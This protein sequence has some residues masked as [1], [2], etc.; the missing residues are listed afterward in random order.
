MERNG[1][2]NMAII[3]VRDMKPPEDEM[4]DVTLALQYPL[5]GDIT[6]YIQ[7]AIDAVTSP[8]D[9]VVFEPELHLFS[10][11]FRLKECTLNGNGATLR[12][13]PGVHFDCWQGNGNTVF[14]L[15]EG[16]AP[17]RVRMM[18]FIFDGDG[19]VDAVLAFNSAVLAF[20]SAEAEADEE[21]IDD[22]IEELEEL[23]RDF[24]DTFR[25]NRAK[26]KLQQWR[27]G[28]MTRME[29]CIESLKERLAQ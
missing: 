3:R 9:E 18:N 19:R 7:A 8:E 15:P 22:L 13:M 14:V 11:S 5:N 10:R 24:R 4:T 6:W 17:D 20:N 21:T 28:R 29:E 25:H 27:E 1:D 16:V 12:P 26:D 2:S 23:A